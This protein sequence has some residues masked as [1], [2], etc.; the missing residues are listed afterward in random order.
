[1]K[2]IPLFETPFGIASLILKEI[3]YRCE[4]FVRVQSAL[5]GKVKD[6]VQECAAFCCMAGAVKVYATGSDELSLY[7]LHCNVLNMSCTAHFD[8]EGKLIPVTEQNVR[9]WRELYNDKMLTVDNSAYL[10]GQ[11]E[12]EIVDSGGAYFVQDEEQLIGLGWVEEGKLIGIVSLQKGR[13]AQT[14]RT[15]LSAQPS[16]QVCLEVVSTNHRAIRLYERLGFSVTG[17]RSSWYTVE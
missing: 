3:P 13:G 14:V 8:A 4:A 11:M 16:E 15:L 9:Q 1:M 5:P 6:L 7:P 10:T 12:D 17:I 2:D